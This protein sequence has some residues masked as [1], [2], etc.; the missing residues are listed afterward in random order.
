VLAHRPENQET[1][2]KMPWQKL[3]HPSFAK[4]F[5]RY[6]LGVLLALALIISLASVVIS[7][8]YSPADED[9]GRDFMRGTV[10]L[11]KN[12]LLTHPEKE[13]PTILKTLEPGF[14][15][16]LGLTTLAQLAQVE[17]LDDGERQEIRRGRLHLDMDG[18]IVYARL[19][20]SQQVLTVGPLSFNSTNGDSLL[21]DGVHA[22][23]AWWILTAL[24]CGILAW[25]VFRRIWRDLMALRHTAG[26]WAAGDLAIRSPKA[27][28]LLLRP[29][30]NR[31]NDMAENL[32]HQMSSHYA[33]RHATALELRTP[34]SRLR[35][36]LASLPNHAA[37]AQ[38]L[39][40]A[41]ADL[42]QDVQEM[43]ELINSS[44]RYAQ[45]DQ[46]GIAVEWQPVALHTWF[47][48]LIA[49]VSLANPATSIGL[50]CQTDEAEFDPTLLNIAVRNLLLNALTRAETI[51]RVTVSKREQNLEIGVEDDG[52]VISMEERQH[53]FE[54]FYRPAEFLV[55]RGKGQGLQLSFTRLIAQHHGGSAS[56]IE[57]T[58]GTMRFMLKIPQT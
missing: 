23:V 28:S 44:M 51:I 7:H 46:G 25:L 3:R 11:I 57:G 16:P 43:D 34:L 13:W 29:L 1:I 27:H 49:T 53:I 45:L 40:L 12:Q 4:L 20:D 2:M 33:H 26:R 41:C 19:G 42:L 14:S 48:E 50:D 5:F 6:Y 22:K 54:P 18:L 31:L 8:L 32:Q 30:G 17:E 55:R 39:Q 37:S 36:G 9:Y 21:T 58:N 24:G 38:Q 52:P 47:D 56:V 15:Y 10:L 35:S